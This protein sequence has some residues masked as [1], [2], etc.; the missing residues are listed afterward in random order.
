MKLFLQN[1]KSCKNLARKNC[2]IFFLQDL[3]KILQENYL[4]NSCKILARFF[5]SYKK[6]FIF[7]ARLAR[8]GARSC[9]SCQWR[10]YTR[11][12]ALVNLT[13]ALVNL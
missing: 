9:K 13:F 3:I 1:K 10:I 8:L 11:A 4:T 5:T 6:S 12:C 7:S 2:K